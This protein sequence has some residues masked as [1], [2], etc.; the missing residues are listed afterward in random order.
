MPVAYFDG[1]PGCTSKM[2]VDEDRVTALMPQELGIL[3]PFQFHP[4]V[5][6]AP[7]LLT[8]DLSYLYAELW[9][10]LERGARFIAPSLPEFTTKS[11]RPDAL[12]FPITAQAMNLLEEI[13]SGGDLQP[14][15][16]VQ[17]TLLGK[18]PRDQVPALGRRQMLESWGV[19]EELVG[20]V[21]C[22]DDVRI[23]IAKLDWEEEILPQW[24]LTSL[25]M[26]AA[27]AAIP[28]RPNVASQFEVD[29]KN[30]TSG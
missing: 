23:H 22:S 8:W 1:Q 9:S 14:V 28:E 11:H 4:W 17:A 15:L 25:P 19:E 3:I 27:L 18:M 30:W 16:H 10:S 12:R 5:P 6:G 24:N 29:P 26:S 21:R 20:P 13:R 7:G 2:V